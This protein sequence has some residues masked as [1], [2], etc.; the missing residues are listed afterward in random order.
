MADGDRKARERF[1]AN[2]ERWRERRGFS[3]GE[4][5]DRSDTDPAE[6]GQI[7]RG[8]AEA[9]YGTIF[10]LGGALAVDP[11]ELFKG[12]TWESPAT[13]G[14]GYVVEDPEGD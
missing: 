2:I 11:G 9:D 3:L 7:L 14:P 8:E 13:G 5:A 12:V 10:R 4:L 1:A 6:L